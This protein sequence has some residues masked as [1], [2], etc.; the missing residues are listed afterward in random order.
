MLESDGKN[1]H[2]FPTKKI[3]K[4]IEYP[5]LKT[6]KNSQRS[7]P[8]AK[9]SRENY[10]LEFNKDLDMVQE[11]SAKKS[12]VQSGYLLTKPKYLIQ[13]HRPVEKDLLLSSQENQQ[14]VLESRKLEA[15][16]KQ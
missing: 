1:Q 16:S 8:I 5:Q 11:T 4:L 3:N 2:Y 14:M 13:S 9:D 6:F 15:Q 7:G 10:N 12:R